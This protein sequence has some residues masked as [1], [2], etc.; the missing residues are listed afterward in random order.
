MYNQHRSWMLVP[1][2]NSRF[3][4]KA[5][6]L[7]A[8][9]AIYDLEDGVPDGEKSRARD[10]L[11]DHLEPVVDT[12][13]LTPFPCV[14]VNG[15]DTPT[16]QIDLEFCIES[17]VPAI[18]IPK[19]EN[20]QELLDSWHWISNRSVKAK[21]ST[22]PRLIAGIESALGLTALTGLLGLGVLDGLV[23]GAEDFALD[24]GLGALLD[25]E[26][27]ELIYARSSVATLGRAAKVATIDGVYPRLGNSD[28]LEGDVLRSRRLGFT[29]KCAFHPEQLEPINRIFAPGKDDY[30]YSVR[31]IEAFTAAEAQ[32][33]GAIA[34]EGNLVDKPIVRRAQL[35][36]NAYESERAVGNR[37][38]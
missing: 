3:L 15:R 1:A 11:A 18:L 31:L 26:T 4:H 16:H 10:L 2:N 21:N 14:R 12:Q 20:S 29:G 36:V 5:L 34:F 37:N 32:G 23:F 19:V 38:P 30:E 33:I 22:Q 25:T 17:S 9:V 24:M 28:D 35:V 8:D 7:Q 6:A 27:A 13:A